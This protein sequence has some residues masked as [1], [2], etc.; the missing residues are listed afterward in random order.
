[1]IKSLNEFQRKAININLKLKELDKNLN[2]R[3]NKFE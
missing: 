3:V 1:M 2:I